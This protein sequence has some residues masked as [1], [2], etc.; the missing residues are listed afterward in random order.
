M[1]EVVFLG[2]FGSRNNQA[3]A[4][5][6]DVGAPRGFFFCMASHDVEA[7]QDRAA[8]SFMEVPLQDVAR[9]PLPEGVAHAGLCVFSTLAVAKKKSDG[10]QVWRNY[11]A[12]VRNAGG[13][14]P[15]SQLREKGVR[16]YNAALIGWNEARTRRVVTLQEAPRL[17]ATVLQKSEA[18]AALNKA[19]LLNALIAR[20]LGEAA[21]RDAIDEQKTL[22]EESP[23][24]L[25]LVRQVLAV[26]G[27]EGDAETHQLRRKRVPQRGGPPGRTTMVFSPIS[28]VMLAKG[29]CYETAKNIVYRI[30]RDYHNVDLEASE[31]N[32]VEEVMNGAGCPIGY[33][34]HFPGESGRRALALD[35]QGSCELLCLIPGSDFSVALRKRAVDTFLRV[36]GGD[37]SL[38]DR[39]KANNK[40]QQEHPLRSVGEHAEQRQAE[41]AV[42]EATRRQKVEE[43]IE[44]AKRME[45]FEEEAARKR[46]RHLELENSLL[47]AQLDKERAETSIALQKVQQAHDARVFTNVRSWMQ[48][49][50]TNHL[51]KITPADS[52]AINDRL[53]SVALEEDRPTPELGRPICLEEYLRKKG[54]RNADTKRSDFGRLVSRLWKEKFPGMEIH[55]KQVYVHGQDLLVNAYFEKDLPLIEE[56]FLNGH[57]NVALSLRGHPTLEDPLK[58]TL[59]VLASVTLEHA[60]I[61][62]RRGCLV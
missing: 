53:R 1:K 3:S 35:V 43:S 41:E 32:P 27:V 46:M 45:A 11:A 7:G 12:S 36:E 24:D 44:H 30:F 42:P 58:S 29:C 48:L 37:S 28:L 10:G 31:S 26:F 40:F 14:D 5:F 49:H 54:V 2:A 15:E 18:L 9:T 21:A 34:I 59:Q 6:V 22:L 4:Y 47:E 50:E 8:R 19:D 17:L 23:Q 57:E 62:R 25:Q 56:A 39:I 13:S 55:K 61:G 51:I 33:R 16:I 52:V 20:G 38:I 60:C